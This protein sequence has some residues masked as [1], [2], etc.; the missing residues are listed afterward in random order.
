MVKECNP[1]KSHFFRPTEM[2]DH[3]KHELGFS[4]SHNRCAKL[5]HRICP[6]MKCSTTELRD[7][8]K[9]TPFSNQ[10]RLWVCRMCICFLI[11]FDNTVPVGSE[12]GCILKHTSS[13][14]AR[15]PKENNTREGFGCDA[16]QNNC[17]A[18]LT[19]ESLLEVGIITNSYQSLG[20]CSFEQSDLTSFN[21]FNVNIL[22]PCLKMDGNSL[23]SSCDAEL[24]PIYIT[25]IAGI[26]GSSSV[27][28]D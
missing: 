19:G 10:E 15:K 17:P 12:I 9:Q 28:T 7:R 13:A 20:I 24:A 18:A 16:Y 22:S 8:L 14:G 5:I 1:D 3:R 26:N 25:L 27:E 4:R 6:S 23:I 11:F 2:K 21:S